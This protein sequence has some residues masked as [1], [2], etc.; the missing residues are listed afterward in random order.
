VSGERRLR[1]N[2]RSLAE[3]ASVLALERKSTTP[4]EVTGGESV[5]AV[6]AQ[7]G[8]RS[9]Q[10]THQYA[11]LWS[12][13]QRGA[14]LLVGRGPDRTGRDDG[15]HDWTEHA[16]CLRRPIGIARRVGVPSRKC[17]FR[18]VEQS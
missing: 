10:S 6:Q 4:C 15:V 1:S 7:L 18:R 16:A 5:K 8:H 3:R 17:A 9:E 2:V 12:G 13:A 11:H 14:D